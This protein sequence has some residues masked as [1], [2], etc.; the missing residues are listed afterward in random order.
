[1]DLRERTFD[2]MRKSIAGEKCDA[3]SAFL[4][5]TYPFYHNVTGIPLDKYFHD[6]ATQLEIQLEVL[7]QLDGVGNPQPD[8][9]SVAEASS[10]GAPVRFDA[11]GFISV[12]EID[13]L[14]SEE[15]IEE[16]KFS[17]IRGDNYMKV[18]LETLE[19]FVAH[20]PSR[21]KVNPPIVM[22]PFTVGSQMYGTGDFC[23]ATLED[24]DMVET[25]L[26]KIIDAEIEYIKEME[27][28]MGGKL[29]HILMCDDISSFL[30]PGVYREFVLPTYERVFAEFPNC[31][32]W[33]HNDAK[34]K[35]LATIIA[36]ESGFQAWQYGPCMT[37]AEAAELTK[38]KIT[39]FGGLAPL[40]LA[41]YSVEETE[42]VCNRVIDEF[43]GNSRMVLGTMGS[44]NQVPI[45]NLRK[46]LE[47]A[48]SRKI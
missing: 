19:Y 28:I 6:P 21:Y 25:F 23:M 31:Q 45:P 27:K 29:G 4:Y 32:R 40:D 39:M 20:T 7:D 3:H 46:V 17:G 44:V 43:N 11:E 37:P 16:L 42:E 5:Y 1:M 9:G 38:G 15:D 26:D 10:F 33:L 12:H 48:D 13:G 14:E 35:H 24:P 34:A 2:R 41:G 30:S 36:E 8:V 47:V 18:A 22:G